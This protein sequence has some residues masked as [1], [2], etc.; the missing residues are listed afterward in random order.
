MKISRREFLKKSALAA[1]F[2]ALAG[3]VGGVLVEPNIIRT[4]HYNLQSAKWPKDMAPIR[5]AVVADLHVGSPSVSLK[6]IEKTSK[7]LNEMKPDVI[8][9]L[10]DYLTSIPK[11]GR[12]FMGKYVPPEPIGE[13]LAALKAPLGVYAVLGNHDWL[14]NGRGMWDA[15]E[16]AGIHVLENDAV[17]IKSLKHSFWLAGLADDTTRHSDMGLTFSKITNDDPVILM[18]H[19]PG[20][21]LDRNGK[22]VV[23]LAGHTHGGQ[24]SLP[25]IGAPYHF[26]G[27]APPALCLRAYKGRRGGPDRQQRHRH[28]PVSRAPRRQRGPRDHRADYRAC[29]LIFLSVSAFRGIVL[30]PGGKL[31]SIPLTVFRKAG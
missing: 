11:S 21:F 24:V 9:L 25:F 30:R 10:G 3:G 5:I 2:T 4:A 7:R 31:L 15:L 26:V 6:T 17:H 18:T 16:K 12:V 20:T 1:L 19:D 22:P 27:R 23:T 29:A 13:K 8:L 28:Q 14:C